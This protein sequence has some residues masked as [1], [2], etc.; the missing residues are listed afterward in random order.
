MDT[1]FIRGYGVCQAAFKKYL[2]KGSHGAALGDR[3]GLRRAR[4]LPQFVDR[5]VEAGILHFAN[6]GKCSWQKY[7]QWAW[8]AVRA[9]GFVESENRW[10]VQANG[11]EKLGCATPGLFSAFHGQIH[12]ATGYAARLAGAR[13]LI[14]LLTSISGN[15]NTTLRF[16]PV[17]DHVHGRARRIEMGKHRGRSA[18]GFRRQ[19]GGQPFQISEH[20]QDTGALRNLFMPPVVAP[21]RKRR[22]K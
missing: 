13:F 11:H 9:Q 19:T 18:S 6:A 4:M 15:E 7:A 3:Q 12:G 8:I 10:R 22:R 2:R 16:H 21:L 5:T 1:P 14:I 20:R 17:D